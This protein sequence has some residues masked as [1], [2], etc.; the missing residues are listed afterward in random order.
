MKKKVAFLFIIFSLLAWYPIAKGEYASIINFL[1]SSFSK[2][3]SSQAFIDPQLIGTE[4]LCNLF[5]TVLA[6]YSGGGNP[7]T[8]V[9][10]WKIFDPNN[11]LVFD[12]FGGALFETIAFTFSD[13][14]TYRV[15][16]IVKRAGNEIYSN[17]LQVQV[18]PG[19]TVLLQ[20]AYS[21]CQT[22]PIS[23]S[24]IS[25]TSSNFSNYI[26]EWK[27]SNG[28]AIGSQNTISLNTA[29]TY[30]VS[31]YFP[32]TNGG[33]ECEINVSTLLSEIAD[34]Q[35]SATN[36]IVCP[37][38]PTTFSTTPNISGTWKYL[39]S[40]ES[41][42]VNLGY[43]NSIRIQP[44]QDL[45]GDGDYDIIFEPDQSINP[46]CLPI[47]SLPLKYFTQPIFT[48][49]P[50][51]EATDCDSFDG[52]LTITAITPLDYVFIEGL[53]TTTPS[54]QPGEQ[55]TISGLKSGT[56]SLVGILGICSNSF[57][58]LVALTNPPQELA[59][60]IEDIIGE[61]CT[62]S[63]KTDGRFNIKF[64]NP[65]SSGNY[66][67]INIKGTRVQE[68][69]YTNVSEIPISIPGGIYFMKIFSD[70]DCNIPEAK[71]VSV[72][73]LNQTSF[74]IPSKL[75]I[76]QSYELLPETS[77]ALEFTLTNVITGNQEIK[78]SGEVFLITEAGN[79]S[80][81]GSAFG[82][83]TIC[84]S[85]KSL[86]VELVDPVN[87]EPEL[88]GQDC[89][90]NLTYQANIFGTDPAT[91]VFRWLDENNQVVSTGQ[92]LNPISF[93]LHKLDVQPANSIACPIPPIE[94]EIKEPVL[95]VE[96]SI[97][98]T[99]LCEYGPG[100]I[101]SATIDLP[102]EV[103]Q[104]T[105]RRSDQ[106]GITNLPQFDNQESIT[107]TEAGVYEVSV[108]SFIPTI[109]KNC[110]LG[111]NSI[112]IE[113]NPNKVDFN[114][115]SSLSICEV[116]SF[117]PESA[118]PLFFEVTR[119]D[120]SKVDLSPDE[121]I[122]L[123][124]S[125]TYSFYGFDP[126]ISDPL[127]PELKFLDVVVNQKI[128]FSPIFIEGT[129]EGTTT[130]KAEIG[131]VNPA[132]AE[133]S[134]FDSSGNIIGTDQ[135]LTLTTFGQFSLDVRPLGSL[136]C[137]QIPILF[138]IKE[139]VLSVEV[140]IVS[141][142]LCEYG[143]GAI[144]SATIDLPDEVNQITWRRSDQNGITNLPQFDNQESIT[145]TEAGV[146]EVSVFSFI[147]TINKNCELGRNSIEIEIN[148]N[149][150][151]FN[152]PSSLSI[153]EVYSF[154]PES[155]Q[156]LFFEVTRPDA[157]KVD[158]SPDESIELNQS[159]TYSFYGFDPTISDPLCPELKF[160]DVVVNQKI[161][162]SPI[163]IEETC[164]GTTTYKAEI[165]TSDP[166]TALFSWFDNLGNLLGTDQFLTLSTFGQF[167]L[168]VQPAGSIP[169][170]QSPITFAV[171][172][173]I[174]SQQVILNPDPLCPDADSAIIA[175]ET[176]FQNVAIIQWWFTNLNGVQS[177]LTTELN[178]QSI[179]ARAEG[180]YEVRILNSIGCQLGF[181]RILLMRSM[182]AV[183]PIVEESYKVCPRYEISPN[184]NP[185]SFAS[186][187]WYF[188]D[189]LVST[190]PV[191]KPIQP[192][193]YSLIVESAEGCSYSTGFI[194]EEECELR[195][196]YP[197]AIKPGNPE[198]EF[199]IYTNFLVDK[200]KVS[201]FNRWGGLIYFCEKTDL[202]LSEST[203]PWNGTY[204]GETIPNGTYSIRIDL[205]NFEKKITKVQNGFILVIE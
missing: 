114:I 50:F 8:D 16:L 146:Y 156:P 171:E 164:E 98:S 126:T 17:S 70:N 144:I 119:P 181:D 18:V 163:F 176:D 188:E 34:Y 102:D 106:N 183:R 54:L 166:A 78:P 139:P 3:T 187:E 93:G 99:K 11:Q 202:I 45:N 100:A 145:V 184:I 43:G 151:D 27:D 143:P 148:P 194:T 4:N 104:I 65:P 55:Y 173:P 200:L 60:V 120:A 130:Y 125:G 115:P 73:S 122:E 6:T 138:E 74:N 71:E 162:F 107:V 14:G 123:N 56:Y 111:R 174:L 46:A 110:E 90:G 9:Y 25:P 178:K 179:T 33:K 42:S 1:P 30:S 86:I 177:Q 180:T 185:G 23:L 47:K 142:K 199:L 191:Y 75:S 59:F 159:G 172:S 167:S 197:N 158:L 155:A 72:P 12:R 196:S 7:I 169:C 128:S 203:C 28:I 118:Q 189:Q 10:F 68:G 136:P 96:V 82:S 131:A 91:V 48:V 154:T 201:I 38:L 20:S 63:G 137:D 141:T 175:A 52:G 2:I 101:I 157:S 117:T 182:D 88:I 204:L 40:G 109:N 58:S 57:G 161:S 160:L 147:P 36:P 62:P 103:N 195:V 5:G 108:F 97:V 19:P 67:I 89:F 84:P 121:S 53:G 80:L 105:W 44:N 168:D 31:F 66:Q 32:G 140:S 61:Q 39:K 193:A 85:E 21:F 135:F 152:I 64:Q 94:F 29:G 134:W 129:C 76:C 51:T 150:V 124:Q 192:G 170:D 13:K 113:I 205:E 49:S 87:F 22:D 165:G 81:I 127:C 37:D 35:I 26:F 79:Y 116:Y 95:S 15:E 41:N 149:K 198:K 190:N 186:Y 24:A 132:S 77:Q 83:S 69:P 133:F 92:I 112:E 153:C